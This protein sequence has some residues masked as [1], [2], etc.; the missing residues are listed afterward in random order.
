MSSNASHNVS[1]I[2]L[3]TFIIRHLSSVRSEYQRTV[4]VIKWWNMMCSENI[5]SLISGNQWFKTTNNWTVSVYTNPLIHSF[6]PLSVPFIKLYSDYL[7]PPPPP[8]LYNIWPQ[9]LVSNVRSRN[10]V[11]APGTLNMTLVERIWWVIWTNIRL[12]SVSI[13]LLCPLSLTVTWVTREWQ[14]RID[15]MNTSPA[16]DRGQWSDD[17]RQCLTSLTLDTSRVL[18]ILIMSSKHV[19]PPQRVHISTLVI[20]FLPSFCVSD[21]RLQT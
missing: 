9:T 5:N 13:S 14:V 10:S 11:L 17:Q 18:T 2:V 12:I 15:K 6:K 7:Q 1:R 8:L 20:P 16:G 3:Q 4:S 19:F 21:A